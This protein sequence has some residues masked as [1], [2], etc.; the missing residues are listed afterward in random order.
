MRAADHV[1]AFGR[2]AGQLV[3]GGVPLD[4]LAARVGST[5]FFA[6]DRAAITERVALLRATLPADVRLSYAIKANPMP[7]VVQ[8][9]SGLVDAFDVASAAEMR[10][11]LD[12]GGD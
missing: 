12:T 4:R 10:T 2:D 7:A 6:Y 8:H 5:P 1:A 9:L 11:A 3:V